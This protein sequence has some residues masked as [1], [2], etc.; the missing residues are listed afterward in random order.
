M[1]LTT[2][3]IFRPL[4]A[5]SQGYKHIRVESGLSGQ[6]VGDFRIGGYGHAKISASRYF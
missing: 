6:D 3:A 4:Y 5:L 2:V 1:S